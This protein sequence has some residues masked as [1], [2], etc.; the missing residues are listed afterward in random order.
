M[1]RS[2]DERRPAWAASGVPCSRRRAKSFRACRPA[3]CR[4]PG[5]GQKR[6]AGPD[7]PPPRKKGCA[8]TRNFPVF[9]GDR[10][11]RDP[12]PL[13][14][15]SCPDRNPT[16]GLP[17]RRRCPSGWHPMAPVHWMVRLLGHTPSTTLPGAGQ[18]PYPRPNSCPSFSATWLS[19]VIDEKRRQVRSAPSC[20]SL[21][22]WPFLSISSA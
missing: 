14:R 21:Q 22:P 12:H 20:G 2:A 13:A 17:R 10:L 6:T 1:P 19:A 16:T 15:G 9:P 3:R 7:A 4:L 8:K 11:P 5:I 18:P